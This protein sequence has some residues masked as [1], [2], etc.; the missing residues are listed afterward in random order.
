MAD[1]VPI[2]E[3]DDEIFTY[4]ASGSGSGGDVVFL[5]GAASAANPNG[6]VAQATGPL[7]S[8]VGVAAYDYTAGQQVTVYGGYIHELTS[9]AAI[10][11]GQA[12][13]AGA[14][15]RVIPLGANTVDT[16][17]GVAMSTVAGAALPV[18]VRWTR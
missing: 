14:S 3:N 8:V 1:Y 13:C 7:A 9:G 15:G 16:M 11:A 6:T 4:T 18:R 12:V 2:V 10:T 5:S 17:I